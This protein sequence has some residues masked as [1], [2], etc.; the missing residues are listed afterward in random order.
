[1]PAQR[2]SA[3]TDT[4]SVSVL[5]RRLAGNRS[6]LQESRLRELQRKQYLLF[7]LTWPPS[8]VGMARRAVVSFDSQT[9][10]RY[11]AIQ[12]LSMTVERT[13]F[14]Q[15]SQVL[16]SEVP[17]LVIRQVSN[18]EDRRLRNPPDSA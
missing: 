6:Q 4:V 18:V 16:V 14:R 17:H 3:T 7:L 13:S 12:D 1:M 2:P 15:D 8:D 5:V 11:S 10:L 9:N